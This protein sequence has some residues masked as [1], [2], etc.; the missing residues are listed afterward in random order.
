MKSLQAK[1]QRGFLLKCVLR[2]L[3]ESLMELPFAQAPM[4]EFL[5]GID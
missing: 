1:R 5:V 4:L 3:R 2:K